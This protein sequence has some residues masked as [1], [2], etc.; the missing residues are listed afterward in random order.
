MVSTS[1][2][3]AGGLLIKS[4]IL[5]VLKQACDKAT[6]CRAGYQDV[7][8]CCTRGE[9]QKHISHMPPPSV[10]KVAHSGFETQR[11][12]HQKSKT[13]VS[14]APQKRLMSSKMFFKKCAKSSF[15]KNID[16]KCFMGK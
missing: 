4:S 15:E 12:C 3:Y 1:D 8:R 5:P 2:C 9:S 14:V 6:G 11:R 13:G 7:S 10:N 16:N